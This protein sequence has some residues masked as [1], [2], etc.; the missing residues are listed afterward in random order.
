MAA[1]LRL[2]DLTFPRSP[3]YV[4]CDADACARAGWSLV[5]F[6][7]ACVAGGARLL[8]IRAKQ[9]SGRDFLEAAT[10][11]CDRAR[12]AEALVVVNDRADVARLSGAGGLHVGQDDL[13]P[14]QARAVVGSSIVL[15]LST[16]TNEQID[17]AVAEPIQYMAIGPVFGTSSK[18]TGYEA[19]GLERVKHASQAAARASLPLV[20]IGG[21]TLERAQAV[22]DAGAASV[23][24]IG[25]LL[26]TGDPEAR[27]KQYLTTLKR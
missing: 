17:A 4:I 18:D 19:V 10:T 3:L 25:D 2:S 11:I 16:H 8:Q 26:A 24:V 15:G 7:D 20:A 9:L 6:A 13:T 14:R 21:I 1:S 5:D 23:A 12:Q 22:L 27:V